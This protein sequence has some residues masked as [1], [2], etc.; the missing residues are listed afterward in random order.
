[1]VDRQTIDVGVRYCGETVTVL[2]EDEWF[3]VLFEGRP[4]AATPRRY[5]PGAPTI[6]GIAG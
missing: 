4:I 3:R 5:R 6:Y 2:L 1:M